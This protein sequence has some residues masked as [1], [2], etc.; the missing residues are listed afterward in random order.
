[1]VLYL[2]FSFGRLLV[3]AGL[4]VGVFFAGSFLLERIFGG[5]AKYIILAGG[6]FIIMIG[7]LMMSGRSW[8]WPACRT[9][10]ANFPQKGYLS[11]LVMGLIMGLAPC[12]PLIAILSYL[13][14]ISKTWVDGLAYGLAFGLGTFVSPLIALVLLAGFIPAWLK[15]LPSIYTRL[16]RVMCGLVIMV[17]G[18]QLVIKMYR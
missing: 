9:L 8:A 16:L 14:L 6:T 1:L 5:I 10:G 17:L 15:H 11:A 13:G 3:Y 18:L 7:I 2:L 4:G 12:A